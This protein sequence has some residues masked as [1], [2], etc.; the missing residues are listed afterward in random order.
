MNNIFK[1]YLTALS[2]QSLADKTEATNR[3]DLQNLLESIASP[4]IKIIHEE[5]RANSQISMFGTPDFTVKKG[6]L[7]I[8]YVENKKIGENLEKIIKSDQIKK[9]QQLNDNIL[10]TNY[11]DWLLL[12]K[13]EN[14]TENIVR[15]SLCTPDDIHQKGFRV[16][17]KN[18]QAVASLLQQFFSTAPAKISRASELAYELAMRGK[19]LRDLLQTELHRQ[20]IESQH[21]KLYGLYG[22]F[23]QE[24]SSAL[25]M[26]EFAD[27]FAQTL[28]YGLFMAKLNAGEKTEIDLYNAKQHIAN[29]FA[30]IQEMVSFLDELDKPEYQ[31]AKWVI[32]EILAMMNRLDL[33]EIER[34]LADTTVRK[35]KKGDS[36][37]TI[38]AKKYFYRD[39]YIYFYEDF[40]K[41]WDASTRKARGVYYTPPPAVNFIIRAVDDILQTEFGIG[42][43]LADKNNVTMLDFA[44]GTGTFLLEAFRQILEKTDKGMRDG[45]IGAHLL[46]NFY[47]FEYLIAPY[48]VAHLKLSQYLKNDNYQMKNHERLQIYL[49][50]S[51]ENEEGQGNLLLPALSAEGKTAFNI[52]TKRPILVITGNP[53][54]NVKS[55][56]KGKWITK[57]IETYKYLD[58]EKLNEANPKGLQ[59]DYVKFIRFAQYKM[60]DTERGIIAI[61]TNH[62]FL[63]N[64]T[65][66]GMRKSLM[67]DFDKIYLLDLHGNANKSESSP[68]GG[69]DKNIF[70]IRQG[71]AISIL[72]KDKNI[73]NKGIFHA[74]FYG[75]RQSKY[76]E[77]FKG[78][79]KKIK[80]KL[81]P[82]APFYLFTPQDNQNLKPYYQN[83][84]VKDIFP[85][86]STGVKTHRDHFVIAF[87][88]NILKQ[89]I[90]DF[91]NLKI[92]HYEIAY[93][94]NL[95][96]TRD[97]KMA[98]A[99][100]KLA[101]DKHLK[102]SFT[103]LLYRPFDE[104]AYFHHDDAVELPRN[105]VMNHMLAGDNL[106]L[107]TVRQ[108]KAGD[109]WFHTFIANNIIDSTCISNK[110]SETTYLFPLYLY[111]PA[112]GEKTPKDIRYAFGDDN[113]FAGGKKIENLAPEFRKFIDGLYGKSHSPEQILGYIYAILH[114]NRYRTK[115]L[116]FLKSDF[117]RIPFTENASIFEKLATIGND[118]MGAHLLKKLPDNPKITY[119]IKGN[120]LVDKPHYHTDKKRLYINKTQYFTNIAPDI[121]EF[122]IGG[123]QVLDKYLKA[124]KGRELNLDEIENIKN[125]AKSLNFTLSKMQEIDTIWQA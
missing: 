20:Q 15:A 109:N 110:T 111:P 52:K 81:K 1:P 66:R 118:L 25:K 116:Q 13:G 113:P 90:A 5:S 122:H 46:K 41:A 22:A 73:K 79:L 96:N 61:I 74:D 58:G 121:Y 37:E 19:I 54:Y 93:K 80:K 32:D 17:D 40:L 100:E 105:D 92:T 44:T 2:Q 103:S 67:D 11:C 102:K 53:P 29:N 115:Y 69:V 21:S 34:D 119:P 84:A 4:E 38:E 117:P 9:Y 30:L 31:E 24:I 36:A 75:T 7:I 107:V 50:N 51:L 56:N 23:K 3:G 87:D 26:E 12:T 64:P 68:D 104:R 65:F 57:L 114:S 39:P 106:G 101:K 89:R 35:A 59:D 71:V 47:G 125:I 76:N 77:L 86:H 82:V 55:Q 91:C 45:L 48:T 85:I 97:W 112:E 6:A 70:D 108:R 99:R 28:A 83:W 95:Q 8:G 60:Q 42:Q 88:K 18:R 43:G 14:K 10:I 120:H 94:Y 98:I 27:A 62:S 63:D 123:Y 78:D 16:S 33:H 72:V 124:R 49:T